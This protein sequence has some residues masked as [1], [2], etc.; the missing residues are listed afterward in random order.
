MAQTIYVCLAVCK[1]Y[2]ITRTPDAASA[3]RQPCVLGLRLLP[4]GISCAR[5]ARHCRQIRPV[6]CH[7]HWLSV[8]KSRKISFGFTRIRRGCSHIQVCLLRFVQ[9]FT[10]T[11]AVYTFF[12]TGFISK[13]WVFVQGILPLQQ[14]SWR[15]VNIFSFSFKR[16][17]LSYLLTF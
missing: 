13:K 9:Y 17:Y 11:A 10:Y 2:I 7:Q 16:T 4:E 6:H 15:Q 8:H 14:D 12:F 1:D 3:V 5:H